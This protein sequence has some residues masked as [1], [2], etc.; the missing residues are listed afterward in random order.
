MEPRFDREITP[1]ARFVLSAIGGLAAVWI[2]DCLLDDR[3]PSSPHW[4]RSRTARMCE[5]NLTSSI[6]KLKRV[7]PLH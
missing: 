7:P 5:I 6:I 2:I 3:L 4:T 1:L